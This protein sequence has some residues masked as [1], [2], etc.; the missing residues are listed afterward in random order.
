[1]GS[2]YSNFN[3]VPDNEFSNT[4][5]LLKRMGILLVVFAFEDLIEADSVRDITNHNHIVIPKFTEDCRLEIITKLSDLIS[6]SA[7]SFILS[8]VTKGIVVVISSHPSNLNGEVVK[9][10]EN[11]TPGYVFEGKPLVDN[12]FIKHYGPD[13]AKFIQVKESDHVMATVKS[14]AKSYNFKNPEILLIHHDPEM[15]RHARK[16]HMNA[17]L[18][19]DHKLGFRV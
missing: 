16:L 17:I 7:S 11:N 13:I 9:N 12:V 4:A 2:T 15:I 14:S 8:L 19:D 10:S 18:V 1:M 6:E 3:D 5:V